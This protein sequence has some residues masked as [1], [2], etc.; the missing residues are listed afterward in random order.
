M[1][2]FTQVFFLILTLNIVNINS[3]WANANYIHF[4]YNEM[5]SG[6]LKPIKNLGD[7]HRSR[8]VAGTSIDLLIWDSSYDPAGFCAP[9]GRKCLSSGIQVYYRTNQ[10]EK[11]SI[12][13]YQR[14]K[15]ID[16]H[17]GGNITYVRVLPIIL[18]EDAKLLEVYISFIETIAIFNG[19]DGAGYPTY[20]RGR[21]LGQQY[22]SHHGKNYIIHF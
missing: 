17:P 10:N 12:V 18:P 16:A 15:K 4:G 22:I 1:K 2:T 7:V 20:K 13:N 6:V 3:V 5:R 19:M 8:V 14:L 9:L 11:F 21:G